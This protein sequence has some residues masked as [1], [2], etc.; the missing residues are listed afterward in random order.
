MR[1]PHRVVGAAHADGSF[2]GACSFKQISS[3]LPDCDMNILYA[4]YVAGKGGGDALMSFLK[5]VMEDDTS[6]AA[7]QLNSL[8]PNF[9]EVNT[10]PKI[11]ATRT[12][13][14]VV[15]IKGL[16]AGVITGAD[17][18]EQSAFEEAANSFT[19]AGHVRITYL[20]LQGVAML[21]YKSKRDAE[22]AFQMQWGYSTPDMRKVLEVD[23]RA[24]AQLYYSRHEFFHLYKNAV[25]LFYKLSRAVGVDLHQLNS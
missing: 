6:I 17:E 8:T 25:E 9:K 19:K 14:H 23:R 24:K 11:R 15:Y 21:E 3:P 5:Q 16:P 22:D 2:A 20:Q 10:D 13:F 18:S 4:D 1:R 7:I 12:G